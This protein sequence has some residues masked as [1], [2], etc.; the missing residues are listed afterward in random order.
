MSLWTMTD[1][2]NGAPKF[3]VAG[4]L[5][6]A[7]NGSVLFDNVQVGA[8]VTNSAIGIF[9]VDANETSNLLGTAVES[10][11]GYH[12]GWVNRK[13]GTGPV[14]GITLVTGGLGYSNGFIDFTGAGGQGAGA[15][16]AFT[17]NANGA[18]VSVTL[19]SGG[20]DYISAPTAT[21]NGANNSAA[22]FT[23][24]VGGRAN[25]IQYETIVAAG[26]IST[27]G[28]ADDTEFGV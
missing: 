1:L 21:A 23:T 13:V 7:A 24:T 15:N 14:T 25:R 12:A 9:G 18:V 26:S 20:G 3:A 27:D 19:A 6:V 11:R 10:N 22:V 4:G 28:G 17:V 16:A 8:F 5:G 2:A